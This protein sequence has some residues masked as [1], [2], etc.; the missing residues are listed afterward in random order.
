MKRFPPQNLI[1]SIISPSTY[2][3]TFRC[4]KSLEVFWTWKQPRPCKYIHT[5]YK[6]IYTQYHFLLSKPWFRHPPDT[7]STIIFNIN[8]TYIF[9]INSTHVYL[10]IAQWARSILYD[11]IVA[12]RVQHMETIAETIFCKL[13]RRTLLF[14]NVWAYVQDCLVSTIGNM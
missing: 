6:I 8:F 7:Y 1:K 14:F 2:T 4:K 3:H 9:C 13:W 5:S 11:L 10:W 12:R